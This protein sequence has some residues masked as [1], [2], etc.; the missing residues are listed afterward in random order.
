LKMMKITKLNFLLWMFMA[1]GT[2]FITSCG[3]DDDMVPTNTDK[4]VSSFQFQIS[5]T[6][7]LEVAFSNFSQNATS[8]SWNFGD[9]GNSTEKDPVYSYSA[10]GSYTVELTATGAGGTH[11]SSK[12]I[13]IVDPNEALKL[14]T[15]EDSKT[16]KLFR[17]GTCLSLGPNASDPAQWW[18]GLQNNGKRPCVYDQTFTFGLD[19][20]FVFDDMG[21]FWGENDPWGGTANHETCFEPTAA[22]MVNKDGADVSAWGSGTH[23]FTYDPSTGEVSLNGLGAWMG[24]VHTVGSPDLYSNIPTPSRTFNVSITQ[25]EGYDLMTLTYD[26]GDGNAGGGGLWTCVYASYSDSSLEPEIVTETVEFGEDLEDITPTALGHTFSSE[27]DFELLGLISGAST[28][29]TGVDDPADPSG[30]KVGEFTRV[31][32]EQYQEAKLQIS[33]NP[34]DINFSNFSTVSIDVYLPSSNDYSGALSKIVVL[35]LADQ[36]KT[37]QWWTNITQYETDGATPEDQWVTLTYDLNAPTS[38]TG[39]SPLDRNDYDM[40]FINIG[41]GGHTNG[42]TFYIRNLKFQ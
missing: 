41:S 1:V 21:M 12:T 15:G 33:P 37:E 3:E 14:L 23:S 7:F 13:T 36:S 2:L 34:R 4:P 39:G 11:T 40:F 29:V 32:T 9:G 5:T 42:G 19:G 17:E 35:G 8:Y 27:T 31:T 24:L 28:I 20:S 6:D 10:G 38:G 18:P 26:Y 25:N 30:A 16:W 22:N